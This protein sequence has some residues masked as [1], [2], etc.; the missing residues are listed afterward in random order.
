YGFYPTENTT[1]PKGPGSGAARVS[2]GG[3]WSHSA[4]DCRSA[5]RNY[6]PPENFNNCSG[7]R[8]CLEG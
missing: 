8:L 6:C 4:R 7:L 2:R 5:Y 3:C 1:D